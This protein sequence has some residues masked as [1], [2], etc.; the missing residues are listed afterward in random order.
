MT[1]EREIK[2]IKDPVISGYAHA[3]VVTKPWRAYVQQ[4]QMLDKSGRP[5]RFST[6]R[7]ALA[8]AQRASTR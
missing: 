8:A 4:Q 7:A 1:K 6:E 2:T 3:Y 5:R